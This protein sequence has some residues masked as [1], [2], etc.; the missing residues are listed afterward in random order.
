M[1]RMKNKSNHYYPIKEIEKYI[2][3]MLIDEEILDDEIKKDR[4]D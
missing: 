4:K 1:M 3:E 2:N